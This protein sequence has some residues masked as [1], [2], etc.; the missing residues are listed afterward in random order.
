MSSVTR[1]SLL[2]AAS[3][4]LIS[5]PG[6]LLP[7]PT[8]VAAFKRP[9]VEPIEWL[10][11]WVTARLRCSLAKVNRS[12][13]CRVS[14]ESVF[15][16]HLT[17]AYVSC[18]VR[19]DDGVGSTSYLHWAASQKAASIARDPARWGIVPEQR[20]FWKSFVD[21]EFENFVFSLKPYITNLIK[22]NVLRKQALR[23]EQFRACLRESFDFMAL[24][25]WEN[26]GGSFL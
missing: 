6:S 8:K 2:K 7:K 18:R 15:I 23:R 25:A 3:A 19:F 10:L 22:I 9:S 13:P 1:R 26:E 17:T 14:I 11:P 21:R 5:G 12:M 20:D 24:E 16:E 4:I